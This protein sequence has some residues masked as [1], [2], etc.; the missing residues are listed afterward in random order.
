MEQIRCRSSELRRRKW[1]ICV[2]LAGPRRTKKSK[3]S[4]KGSPADRRTQP[5]SGAASKGLKLKHPPS[6]L[7]CFWVLYHAADGLQLLQHEVHLLLGGQRGQDGVVAPARQL[8]VVVGV[9]GRDELQA[10]V[11]HQVPAL[12][13]HVLWDRQGFGG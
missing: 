13:T 7:D 10:G 4:K 2:T 1:E 9:V 6:N 12:P 5:D 8:G 3:T 11:P